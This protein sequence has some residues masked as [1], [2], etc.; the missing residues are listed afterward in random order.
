MSYQRKALKVYKSMVGPSKAYTKQ[1]PLKA[2]QMGVTT[3]MIQHATMELEQQEVDLAP[4]K[5]ILS[6][7]YIEYLKF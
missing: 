3:A 2:G 4:S 1:Y 7:K 5:K 6:V